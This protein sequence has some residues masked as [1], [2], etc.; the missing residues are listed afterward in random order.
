MIHSIFRKRDIQKRDTKKTYERDIEKRGEAPRAL[1]HK[2]ALQST[3]FSEKETYKRDMH[4]KHA[5][6]TYKR[7]QRH[8]E[9]FSTKEHYHTY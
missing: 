8:P 3:L 2:R 6:E 4:K 7:E 1:L 9:L 5:K